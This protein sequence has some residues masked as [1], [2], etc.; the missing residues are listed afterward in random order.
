MTG[1][2]VPPS[3][4]PT[5]RSGVWSAVARYVPGVTVVRTYRRG[6]LRSDLVADVHRIQR[7][8]IMP[9]SGGQLFGQSED[10]QII[11]RQTGR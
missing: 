11:C 3:S 7:R 10:R 5:Q 4:A 9:D 6:W 2:D 1:L 8:G